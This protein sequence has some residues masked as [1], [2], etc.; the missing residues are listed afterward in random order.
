MLFI[1]YFGLCRLEPV[2]IGAAERMQETQ[3]TFTLNLNYLINFFNKKEK[4][5]RIFRIFSEKGSKPKR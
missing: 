1:T 4:K 2:G 5:E 3:F